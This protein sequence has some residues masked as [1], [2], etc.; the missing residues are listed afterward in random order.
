MSL[1][2][3]K[4]MTHGEYYAQ[5]LVAAELLVMQYGYKTGQ[6]TL[7]EAEKHL[8]YFEVCVSQAIESNS[9]ELSQESPITILC[10]AILSKIQEKMY[11]VIERE[12]YSGGEGYV[13]ESEEAYFIQQKDILAMKKAYD[14]DNGY[15]KV[16]YSST[17]LAKMLCDADISP[18]FQEGRTK[19][20]GRKI[21]SSRFMELN[22]KKL[23]KIADM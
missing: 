7:G 19:R 22:K 12:N 8:H 21:G 9:L 4:L 5:L 15:P 16:E 18:V 6:L 14:N 1:N 3:L 2:Y 17:N 20:Y 23:Y 10:R 13:L 11:V